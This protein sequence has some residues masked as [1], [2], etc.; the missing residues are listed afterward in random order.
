[1]TDADLFNAFFALNP[2]R[3]WMEF[4]IFL[5]HFT[6]RGYACERDGNFGSR[7]GP[8]PIYIKIQAYDYADQPIP[9]KFY[10]F[11]RPSEE[12][13]MPDTLP[14]PGNRKRI[15]DPF[16]FP[17]DYAGCREIGDDKVEIYSRL[18]SQLLAR[19]DEKRLNISIKEVEQFYFSHP[20]GYDAFIR[21]G[22]KR[23]QKFAGKPYRFKLDHIDLEILMGMEDGNKLNS[24][25]FI[26]SSWRSHQVKGKK[27]E[28][29]LFDSGLVRKIVGNDFT[30]SEAALSG[31][32]GAVIKKHLLVEI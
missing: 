7:H 6:E 16:D 8:E 5:Q 18:P 27:L 31:E 28:K 15:V 4:R 19:L 30:L 17:D 1:M 13:K 12:E 20:E 25:Y 22:I 3:S 21:C 32:Y 29:K 2:P 10:Y 26:H 24:K 23:F 9:K 14:D 11:I